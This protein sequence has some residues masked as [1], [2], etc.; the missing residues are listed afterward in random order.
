[1]DVDEDVAAAAGQL[2]QADII[3][4]QAET[5]A[6]LQRQVRKGSEYKQLT[7]SKLKE[8]AARLK[9]YRLRVEALQ[10]QQDKA[11]KQLK[12]ASLKAK[13]SVK[14]AFTQTDEKRK[15]TRASQTQLSGAVQGVYKKTLVDN[16]VQ[17]VEISVDSGVP[18]KR[19]RDLVPRLSRDL[20]EVD[21]QALMED[22][23]A[24]GQDA[25]MVW[26]STEPLQ[27]KIPMLG[28]SD[29]AFPHE[30]SA[31]LDAELAF[32]DSEDGE[33]DARRENA[34]VE[35]KEAEAG[36]SGLIGGFDPTVLDEIDKE[37]ASSSDEDKGGESD[38]KKRVDATVSNGKRTL[39]SIDDELDDEFAALDSESESEQEKKMTDGKKEDSGSSSSS[40]SDSSDSSDIDSDEDADDPMIGTAD[41]K[42]VRLAR[43]GIAIEK[44]ATLGISSFT[45]TPVVA[46]SIEEIYSPIVEVEPQ[47]KFP[48]PL[49]LNGSAEA[50]S[51]S[52]EKPSVHSAS[53]QTPVLAD[54]VN[55][56]K[57]ADEDV[58][59]A[60]GTIGA[61]DIEPSSSFADS[62]SI[63]PSEQ[64]TERA[65]IGD[66]VTS[67]KMQLQ[68]PP[69]QNSVSH[70]K[71]FLAHIC[72]L[73]THLCQSTEQVS[74]S[75]V[76][77]FDLLRGNMDIR[78][79]YFAAIM[80]E[81]YPAI[82]E[83]SFDQHCVERQDILKETLLQALT[84]IACVAAER[85]EL[86]LHQSSHT[87]LH[88]IADAIQMPELE[89]VNG[90]DPNFAKR[91]V[92]TLYDKLAITVTAA[93]Y[94]ELAKSLEICTAVFGLDVVTQIFSIERCQ[95]LFSCGAL[96]TK[97]GVI[98]VISHVALAVASKASDTQ[99]PRTRTEWFVDTVID[100][101]YHILDTELSGDDASTDDGFKLLAKC[102]EA[103]VELTLEY[104]GA[105]G[106]DMR[107]RVLS[108]VARWFD[109]ASSDQLVGLPAAFL[110]RLRLAVV[111][112]RPQIMR[113]AG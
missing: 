53:Q 9:E 85:Q 68:I 82:M 99:N 50:I 91:W 96:E 63:S 69:R 78:G 65:N 77:L 92:Q 49:Q 108:A 52:E 62:S 43:G 27:L 18:R 48:E 67:S 29:A 2:S 3:E 19:G 79:L 105:A 51:Q 102:A 84:A 8:A 20:K 113:A 41:K 87:M 80:V 23:A 4:R 66:A 107:R 70:D 54:A 95:E 46:A 25:A 109:A 6:R 76:L 45:A 103:C 101:L 39:M 24:A 83:R 55:A 93:E 40:G 75:R 13:R 88:R 16:G 57:A 33:E 1:M 72:A 81:T 35:T 42:G 104:S 98:S 7:K 5:I 61:M 14:D 44:N 60:S 100:W 22:V 56:N 86:L 111:A 28:T 34:A 26:T 59:N 30:T 11:K 21:T 37:L 90:A 12:R 47:S 110:R 58:V 73:H 32:S 31:A 17:T 38:E 10:E 15:L 71:V 64:A 89:E 106:L 94:Y 74:R 97:G 112:A 36:G